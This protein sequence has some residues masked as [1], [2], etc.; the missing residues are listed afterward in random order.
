MK[1]S[2]EIV[3]ILIE[4]TISVLYY[5][6][7][8]GDRDGGGSGGGV[9]GSMYFDVIERENLEGDRETEGKRMAEWVSESVSMLFM[10]NPLF[11]LSNEHR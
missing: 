4:F 2:A 5:P 7:P 1:V 11:S 6:Q 9:H 8:M 10:C 3:L